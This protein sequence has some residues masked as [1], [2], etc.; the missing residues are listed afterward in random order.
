VVQSRWGRTLG[1]S[2]EHDGPIVRRMHDYC[3][4]RY[5]RA[6]DCLAVPESALPR[7]DSFERVSCG[8]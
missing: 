3:E 8:R 6:P 2:P 7:P 4:E 5:G 1:V